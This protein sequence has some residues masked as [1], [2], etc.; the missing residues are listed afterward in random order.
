MKFDK[1]WVDSL[2]EHTINVYRQI[3]VDKD[4]LLAMGAQVDDDFDQSGMDRNGV[5][6][7]MFSNVTMPG[8]TRRWAIPHLLT[9]DE[10]YMASYAN[11]MTYFFFQPELFLKIISWD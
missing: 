4:G 3:G 11:K 8:T 10:N 6:I 2:D 5:L 7:R 9:T 1:E